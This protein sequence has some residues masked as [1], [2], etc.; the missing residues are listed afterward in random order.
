MGMYLPKL[1]SSTSTGELMNTKQASD[2]HNGLNSTKSKHGKVLNCIPFSKYFVSTAL[3]QHRMKKLY[4][5]YL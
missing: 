3:I 1:V 4:S 2:C 5:E